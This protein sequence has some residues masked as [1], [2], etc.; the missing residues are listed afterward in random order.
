MQ[1]LTHAVKASNR[2]IKPETMIC[3]T[4]NKNMAPVLI[5]ND[6]LTIIVITMSVSE[7]RFAE[8][9]D[10]FMFTIEGLKKPIEMQIKEVPQSLDSWSYALGIE[11]VRSTGS[12]VATERS[13]RVNELIV[14]N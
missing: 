6:T 12:L 10:S 14:K 8:S 2:D 4:L 13:D 3:S 1:T 9:S 7:A 11:V 5:C